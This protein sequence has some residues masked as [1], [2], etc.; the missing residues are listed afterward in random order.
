MGCCTGISHEP[1][2]SCRKIS[3]AMV[4]RIHILRRKSSRQGLLTVRCF[5]T[6]RGR[7]V[8]TPACAPTTLGSAPELVGLTAGC[9][10]LSSSSRFLPLIAGV[11]VQGG[12]FVGTADRG[13]AL[14]GVVDNCPDAGEI[15]TAGIRGFRGKEPGS[16]CAEDGVEFG[17][18]NCGG[19]ATLAVLGMTPGATPC[20]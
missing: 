11:V 15:V 5:L 8:P 19:G 4:L 14:V 20:A 7:A 9:A 1:C 3:C 13:V 17:G 12:G 18:V 2:I 16:C 10:T 6:G